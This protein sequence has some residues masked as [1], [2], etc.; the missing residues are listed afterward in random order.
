MSVDTFSGAVFAS[1]HTGERAS[2]VIRHLVQAFATLG[3]PKVIKTDNGPA[4]T[5]KEFRSFLQQWG[6]KH[7]TGIPYSLTG[8][9]MVERAD[10]N[11]KKMLHL[12]RSSKK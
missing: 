2:D 6:I 9:A 10:Q 11:I 12:Q 7:K 5:S 3:I 4:Y 1:A 8:Q